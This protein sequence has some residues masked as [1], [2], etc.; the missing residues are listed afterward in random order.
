MFIVISHRGVA[1]RLL[2]SRH[3]KV[4]GRIQGVKAV[5]E[6]KVE[7]PCRGTGA[8]EEGVAE[9]ATECHVLT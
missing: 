2:K 6:T 1:R 7:L 9:Y 4:E 5:V 3:D 8:K